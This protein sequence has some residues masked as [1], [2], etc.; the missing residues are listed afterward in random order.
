MVP[1]VAAHRLGA[2]GDLVL[3][4]A[5]DLRCRHV[6]QG[7]EVSKVLA[8]RTCAERNC[9]NTLPSGKSQ[10]NRLIDFAVG[11]ARWE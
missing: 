1:N 8:N 7:A 5:I 4:G 6:K 10:H 11:G 2:R 9:P 3:D